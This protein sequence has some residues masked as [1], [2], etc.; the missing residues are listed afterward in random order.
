M[1]KNL[2]ASRQPRLYRRIVFPKKGSAGIGTGAPFFF[3][4]GR[5]KGEEEKMAP[6]G[7]HR[8]EP[9]PRSK[10]GVA[11]DPAWVRWIGATHLADTQSSPA[12]ALLDQ[13]ASDWMSVLKTVRSASHW[14]PVK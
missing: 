5:V 13:P 8:L 6:A 3:A 11:V 9:G 10:V 2:T 7:Q 4:P 12:L 14:E 1:L